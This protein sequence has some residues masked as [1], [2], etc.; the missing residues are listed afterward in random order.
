MRTGATL[1]ALPGA[2]Q[3]ICKSIKSGQKARE[4]KRGEGREGAGRG[5]SWVAGDKLAREAADAAVFKKI[6][7]KI[8]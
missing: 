4:K 7:N 6:K 1:L 2:S 8:K 3:F 5:A